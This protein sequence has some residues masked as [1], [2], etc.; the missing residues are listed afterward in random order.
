[1][2]SNFNG[3]I[4]DSLRAIAHNKTT[5]TYEPGKDYLPVNIVDKDGF[6]VEVYKLENGDYQFKNPGLKGSGIGD[7]SDLTES[8]V[9]ALKN[10]EQ[11]VLGTAYGKFDKGEK[12]TIVSKNNAG[13]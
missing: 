7:A 6:K 12:V 11:I 3:S 4:E 2:Y 13:E 10:G 5:K 8:E 1:M 9:K